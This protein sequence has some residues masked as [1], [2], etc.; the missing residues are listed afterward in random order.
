[1]AYATTSMTEAELIDACLADDRL[2]QKLL[3][4]RYS[5]GMYTVAFRITSDFELANDV[6]QEAFIK[7]FRGLPGFRRESTLGAWIKAI[8]V[9]TALSKL[10]REHRF[11][12]LDGNYRDEPIDWGHRLDVEYL[13]KAIQGLPEGYRAVFVLIEVEGYSHKEVA[14]MLGISVGTSKSQLFYAK[15]RLRDSISKIHGS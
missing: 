5:Q 4:D 6:L 8:V 14:E 15:K 2:A 12:P 10:R 13:E 3:Y 11:E 9:R 7:V 1:M